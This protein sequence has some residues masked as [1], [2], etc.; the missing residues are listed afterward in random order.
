LVGCHQGF[1]ESAGEVSDYNDAVQLLQNARKQKQLRRL[2]AESKA[3]HTAEKWQAV[4]RV[5]KNL[6]N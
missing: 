2:Y 3:L 1:G 6:H 5:L 4:V